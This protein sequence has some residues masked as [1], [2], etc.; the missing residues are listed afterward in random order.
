MSTLVITLASGAVLRVEADDE[1]E[2]ADHQA[3]VVLPFRRWYLDG[4]LIPD[5]AGITLFQTAAL[6]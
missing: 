2:I 6:P 3:H 5:W 4:D 1:P